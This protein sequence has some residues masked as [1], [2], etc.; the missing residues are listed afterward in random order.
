V[1]THPD[2]L[3]MLAVL[4]SQTGIPDKAIDLL[5]KTIKY[6]PDRVDALF[7]L[8]RAYHDKGELAHAA[9]TYEQYL[10]LVP[11]DS[12]ALYQMGRVLDDKKDPA[13][14]VVYYQ[15]ALAKAPERVDYLNSLGVAYRAQGDFKQALNCYE[16]ALGLQPDDFVVLNNF[17]LVLADQKKFDDAASCFWQAVSVKPEYAEAHLNLG[18]ALAAQ[19]MFD[20]AASCFRHALAVKP[21]YPEAHYNLGVALAKLKMYDEAADSF[22]RA[23]AGKA[24]YAEAHCHL[25]YVLYKQKM[26]EEAIESLRLALAANSEYPDAW[27]W[28]GRIHTIRGDLDKAQAY[29]D[30]AFAIEPDHADGL[31]LAASL[32]EGSIENGLLLRQE[33]AFAKKDLEDEQKIQLAFAL[34]KAHADND[35]HDKSF[36]YIAEGNRLQRQSYEYAIEEDEQLFALIKEVYRED[37][38]AEHFDKGNND[39]TPIFILGMP[40]SGTSLAEQILASHPEVHGAGELEDFQQVALKLTGGRSL[41]ELFEKI[42]RS[43]GDFDESLAAEYLAR[44][45]SHSASATFIT[46]KMP[47]NSLYIGAIRL[48]LP[49]AKIIHCVREPLDNC[50]SIYK[51]LFGGVQKYAYDQEELGRYYLLYLDLMKHWHDLFPGM[52]YD[53]GYERLVAD[54]EGETR[55]LLAHC[56]LSWDERCLAFYKT[57]R[58]VNTLSWTQ[59]RKPIYK[60]SVKLWEKYRKHLE[61]LESTLS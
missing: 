40:R 9:A 2:A 49:N 41:T 20:D 13:Q 10:A 4:Y 47:H 22:R 25:G 43:S 24:Q 14:A 5:R 34:G 56:G 30:K 8:G 21:E 29:C 37:Y 58:A 23:L 44:L 19:K 6:A 45:R 39:Q 12:E 3:Y 46:D 11:D 26:F 55:K 53:L 60:D 7:N 1:P 38:I 59:V 54:Q 57:S 15:R 36:S 51:N 18:L 27:V 31:L 35:D 52:I 33:K 16:Q 32:R 17:G 42:S 48:A 50:F 28:L 61:P